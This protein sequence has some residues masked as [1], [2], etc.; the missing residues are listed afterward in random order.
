[1]DTQQPEQRRR[2][3]FIS[4]RLKL[5]VGFTLLF[6]LVF[7]AAFY[8]FY[9]FATQRAL[10]KIRQDLLDTL[11]GAAAGVDGDELLAL[12]QG[13]RPNAAGQ[14]WLDAN[15]AETDED[16]AR[17]TETAKAAHGAALPGGFSDD[18]RYHN[19]LE[20][21]QRVH[22]VQPQAWPYTYVPGDDEAEVVFLVD[23]W[24]RYNAEKALPF[25]YAY[26]SSEGLQG[27]AYRGL[28]GLV[29]KNNLEIYEDDWGEWIS[30]YRPVVN[31]QGEPVGAIGVDF[32]ADYV[33]Q[34]QQAIIDRV[35]VAFAITYATLFVLVFVVSRRFTRPIVTLTQ[36]AE[37]IGEGDYNQN[38]SGLSRVRFPDEIGT[39]AEVFEIMVA[40]VYQREQS[41]RRK[42][43]ELQIEIDEAKRQKQVSE[44][45]DTGFFQELQEKARTMRRR[46][47][48][49]QLGDE[50]PAA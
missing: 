39:L 4:L 34:V 1:M 35:A 14:A 38:L 25:Q 18:P 20:W 36:A 40:K 32:E 2:G 12:Y 50:T 42:V 13:G 6:S 3:R 28:S 26:V 45:V 8:W 49:G 17:L 46:R 44:I 37:R 24:A 27:N 33:R 29:Q 47:W 5:L 21:L 43:E 41:L 16:Y 7:A 15:N 30:A 23:L 9:T 10:D 31:S 48:E 19:Q 11:A 22:D